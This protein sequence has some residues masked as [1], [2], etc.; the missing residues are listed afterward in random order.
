MGRHTNNATRLLIHGLP[1]HSPRPVA[2]P[3]RTMPFPAI[4]G[5]VERRVIKIKANSNHQVNQVNETNEIH[6]RKEDETQTCQDDKT[7]HVER[8]KIV[9]GH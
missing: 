2:D 1:V 6:L 9:N 4:E 8:A 5:Q 7:G 3:G